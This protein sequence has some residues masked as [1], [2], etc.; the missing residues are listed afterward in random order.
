[1]TVDSNLPSNRTDEIFA[2]AL[3]RMEAGEPLEG[4]IATAPAA[5][6]AELR[7]L[8]TVVAATHP[9][10][11]AELPRRD[12]ARR[13]ANRQAFLQ[14][15]A[16]MRAEVETQSPVVTNAVA[17]VP[18]V[19]TPATKAVTPTAAPAGRAK[20][21][22]AA[23]TWLDQLRAGWQNLTGSLAF[24]P[25]QLAPLVIMLT[26]ISLSTFGFAT[27]AQASVPG[28]IIYGAKQW[29]RQQELNLAAEEDRPDI[30][31]KQEEETAKEIAAAQ[32][33][34]TEPIQETETLFF[35]GWEEGNLL[36]G[37]LVVKPAY[38]LNPPDAA[39]APMTMDATPT[40]GQQVILVYQIVPTQNITDTLG[41][42]VVQGISLTVIEESL[43]VPT[44]TPTP[45]TAQVP[46]GWVP[47]EVLAGD[48]L[49]EIASRTG[50]DV[51]TLIRTNCI[52][53]ADRIQSGAQLL[54]P[55]RPTATPTP[56]QL[57][58]LAVTLT[59]VSTTVSTEV[60][61]PT[62]TVEPDA[63]ATLS[64]TIGLTPTV[65]ISATAT[66]TPTVVVTETEMA[67]T[68]T[69]T[70]TATI[71][72]TVVPPAVTPQPTPDLTVT[73]TT[74]AGTPGATTVMTTT[75]VPAAATTPTP[76]MATAE[77]TAT[78]ASDDTTDDAN[79]TPTTNVTAAPTPVVDASGNGSDTGSTPAATI[80]PPTA[81]PTPASEGR[82]GGRS[83]DAVTLTPTA[84]DRSPLPASSG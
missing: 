1:M 23:P 81:T 38:Q 57:P 35:R 42:Q 32:E 15:A 64:T 4:I 28:D 24:S 82:S 54:A 45:C 69:V 49:S 74:M 22:V 67:A 19:V 37:S 7:D 83:G 77:A 58:A 3:E 18:P 14:A 78:A 8:L 12:P 25:M 27:A 20:T 16:T 21:A 63:T 13:A 9:L 47:I 43:I 76:P 79:E 68:P 26:A 65:G 80:A 48:T 29:L 11:K 71:S 46:T 2:Q 62:Q 30:V 36:L 61:T 53:N 6:H 33:R 84:I 31:K 56:T 17:A 52:G 70:T 39:T 50:T 5:L 40:D 41:R 59:A 10:Q 60:V 55:S 75:T 51:D 66:L 72:G 73:L 34:A 44:V